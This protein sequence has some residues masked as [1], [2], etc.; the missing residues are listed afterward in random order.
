MLKSRIFK[1][2]FILIIIK[3]LIIYILIFLGSSL[4]ANTTMCFKEN[5]PSISTIENTPLDGGECQGK[6]SVNDMKKKA[7][8]VRDIK[9]SGNNYI[10]IFKSSNN[11]QNLD[12]NILEQLEARKK[13]KKALEIEQEKKEL[14]EQAKK[15]YINQCETCHGKKGEIKQGNSIL[16]DLSIENMQEAAKDYKSGVEEKAHSVYGPIHINFLDKKSIEGIK[17]YLDAIP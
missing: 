12:E 2:D 14:I 10:Y 7:W 4:L 16:K 15:L 11:Q 6:Y 17:A 13:V 8:I 5:H 1:K 9:I 3:K